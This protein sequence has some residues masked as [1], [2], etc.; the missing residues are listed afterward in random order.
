MMRLHNMPIAA[1]SCVWSTLSVCVVLSGCG[2]AKP[3]KNSPP[4][5]IP[6]LTLAIPGNQPALDSRPTTAENPRVVPPSQPTPPSE[7]DPAAITAKG[8]A[9]EWWEAVYANGSKIGWMH[10]SM[11]D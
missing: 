2:D 7:I 11:T 6:E 8:H 5:K 4:V 3:A 9:R 10:T 1:R